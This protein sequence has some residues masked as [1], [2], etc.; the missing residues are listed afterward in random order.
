MEHGLGF[1]PGSVQ[2]KRQ[3]WTVHIEGKIVRIG[4]SG[5]ESEFVVVQLYQQKRSKTIEIMG[6]VS[7]KIKNEVVKGQT[8]AV[9][10]K[11]FCI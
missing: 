3:H 1:V 7:T 4:L 11:D 6:D 10:G 9:S 8:E 5:L 2:E